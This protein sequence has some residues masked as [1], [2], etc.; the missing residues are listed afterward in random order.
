[1][2][3]NKIQIQNIEAIIFDFD[4]TLYDKKHFAFRLISQNLKKIFLIQ[5]ER[6]TRYQLKGIDFLSAENFYINFFKKM[7][8][9]LKNKKFT[10]NL[11]EKWYF[12]QYF[13]SFI[14]ILKKSYQARE[15]AEKVFEILTKSKIKIAVFSD[16]PVVA[17]RMTAIGLKSPN[18]N[19]LLYSAEEFGA[20]K[21]CSR[22]FFEIAEKLGTNPDKTLVIGDRADTDG[23]GAKN[24]GMKFLQIMNKKNKK[25]VN[26]ITWKEFV[27]IITQQLQIDM[28]KMQL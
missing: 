1:M 17:E 27:E 26:A 25:F 23:L 21:P 28:K 5:A 3:E 7:S 11:L 2:T 6:K 19:I 8:D 15:G 4:G 16:Y 9:N 22:P 12:E 13:P 18:D 14:K 10:A 24:A 20:L